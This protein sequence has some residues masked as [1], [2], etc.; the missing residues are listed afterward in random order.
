[1]TFRVLFAIAGFF[2]LDIDQRDVKTAFLYE[3]IDQLIYVKM[4]KGTK[5]NTNQKMVYKLQKALYGLKQSLSLWYKRLAT[6]FLKRLG[7]KRI[8]IDHSIFITK[9][10][11][12]GPVVSI[13]IDDIKIMTSKEIRIM[14]TMKADLTSAFLM[15]DIGPIS[16]Y[17]GLK[18]Q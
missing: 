16:F 2:N 17:L 4:P 11:L 9:A 15:V 18:V 6:F 3:L 5:T 14:E 10:G 7:L 1:M 12:D 8:N 13:F